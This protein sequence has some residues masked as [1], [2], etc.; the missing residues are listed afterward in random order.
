MENFLAIITKPDNIPIVAMLFILFFQAWWMLREG[1]V[2]SFIPGRE[3]LMNAQRTPLHD[4]AA[5][6]GAQFHQWGGWELPR[7]YGDAPSEYRAAREGAALHDASYAGRIRAFGGDTLDLLHR[8]STNAVVSLQPGQGAPTVLT[9]DRGRILDLITVLNLGDHVLLITSPQ[10][11][12]TVIQWVDKYTIVEQIE[13][14]DAT[15]ETAMLSVIG[16]G[17]A[18]LLGSLVEADVP[19][20]EPH[21][22]ASVCIGEAKGH[23]VRRD[24][25]G[26]PRFQLLV[27]QG[28]GPRVWRRLV[29]S[30]AT[31]MGQDALEALRVEQGEPLYGRE[32]GEAY[33]P[34]ETG[35][36]GSI[37]FTKGCYIG[38]EVIAR[39]DTY[40]K[41]QR[42]LVSLALSPGA[43]VGEGA[44]LARDGREVGH[45]TSTARVPTT[46]RVVSLAYVRKESAGVGTRLTLPGSDGA[47]A[48]VKAQVL[49]FGPG[50]QA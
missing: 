49:P 16:P 41:V 33:N 23:L 28:D 2:T 20:L 7:S 17:A 13:L 14:R 4:L 19:S 40:Q 47:W 48:E 43:E 29:E 11:R 34:L 27:Q 36:W 30:G 9:T 45:V 39:L 32:L 10:T 35:L 46:G 25:V 50:D 24:M 6:S 38:Q 22:S 5:R 21:Q 37:S 15:L 31:P 26:H 42:H 1:G 44:V 18:G 12:D 3:N 8:L